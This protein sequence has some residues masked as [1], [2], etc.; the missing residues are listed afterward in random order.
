MHRPPLRAGH[1]PGSLGGGWVVAAHA[2]TQQGPACLPVMSL[3]L[4]HVCVDVPLS[5]PDSVQLLLRR[6]RID[7][8]EGVTARWVVRGGVNGQPAHS[9]TSV[10]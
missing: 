7:V 1:H 4:V 2:R 6:Y 5:M 3:T 10:D 9:S 8:P